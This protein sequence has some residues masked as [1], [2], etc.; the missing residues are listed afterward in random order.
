MHTQRVLHLAA[1]MM[2]ALLLT[3][4]GVSTSSPGSGVSTTQSSVI[5]I[6]PTSTSLAPSTTALQNTY[7]IYNYCDT[8]GYM[9]GCEDTTITVTKLPVVTDSS[10]KVEIPFGD[11]ANITMQPSN[12]KDPEGGNIKFIDAIVTLRNQKTIHC[13]IG[14]YLLLPVNGSKPADEVYNTMRIDD[15]Y[16]SGDMV[17][18]G[19][20]AKISLYDI[21]SISIDAPK[22]ASGSLGTV[23]IVKKAK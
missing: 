15:V 10:A 14:V 21:Q 16:L 7:L 23:N 5:A 13:E 12:R 2:F 6:V 9:M 22:D 20:A 3:G 4:C 11:I 1:S 17:D 18:T 19:L 8:R